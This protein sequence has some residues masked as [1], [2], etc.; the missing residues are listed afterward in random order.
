VTLQ[1]ANSPATGFTNRALVKAML[2][3]LMG[4][5]ALMLVVV[6]LVYATP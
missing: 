1:P 4:H 2:V 6:T 5:V 3:F